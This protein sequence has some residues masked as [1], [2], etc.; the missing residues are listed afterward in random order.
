M[1]NVIVVTG[2]GSGIGLAIAS[3]FKD[4][5]VLICGRTKSKIDEAVESLKKDGIDVHGMA[6]DV[7]KREDL[8]ALAKKA[9]SLGNIQCVVNNAAV[10]EGGAELVYKINILGTV[11]ANQIFFPLMKE[12]GIII[13][14]SSIAAHMY[15]MNDGITKLVDNANSPDLLKMVM[16]F[17]PDDG[18]AY[19]VSKRFVI[20]YTKRCCDEYAKKGIRVMSISPGTIETPLQVSTRGN[21]MVQEMMRI[22]PAGRVGDP[23]EIGY[24]VEFLASDKAPYLTGTDI[25]IDG[26]YM[27]VFDPAKGAFDSKK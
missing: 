7:G 19:S 12:G 5:A 23:I 21:T 6:C 8:E 24:L 26:G 3:V 1:K 16:D 9:S 27:C 17:Q 18:L 2:A 22:T 10:V 14:I 11:W 25:I 13:N 4:Y 20:E 15:G